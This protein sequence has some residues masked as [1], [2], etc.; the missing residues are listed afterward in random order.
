MCHLQYAH[1]RPLPSEWLDSPLAGSCGSIAPLGA[2]L[3]EGLGFALK[4]A[5][6]ADLCRGL[7]HAWRAIAAGQAIG[8]ISDCVSPGFSMMAIS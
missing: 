7:D 3:A 2:L 1:R 5:L 6:T 4:A 8:R